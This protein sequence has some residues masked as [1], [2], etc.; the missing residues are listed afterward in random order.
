MIE[1]FHLITEDL[2][3]RQPHPLSPCKVPHPSLCKVLAT[4]SFPCYPDKMNTSTM[5]APST[6]DLDRCPQLTQART[7]ENPA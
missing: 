6:K 7:T 3:N 5:D 1:K 4:L 2:P